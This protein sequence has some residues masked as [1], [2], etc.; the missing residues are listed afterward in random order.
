MKLWSLPVD[1]PVGTLMLLLSL[2]VLGVVALFLLPLD[3]WPTIEPPVISVDVPYPGSHPLE[4]LR[5]VARPLE[6]EISTIP[7]IKHLRAWANPDG[8]G[9]RVEFDWAV[10]LDIKKMDVREAVERVRDELPTGIGNI[11]IQSFLDAPGD[12]TIL[13]GRISAER[14]LSD[15][16][17]LLDRRIR[18]PLERIQGVARVDLGGVEAQ[19]VR[20]DVDPEALRRHGVHAGELSAA[21]R[22]ANLDMALGAIHGDVVR[23]DVRAEGRFRDLDEIRNLTLEPGGIRV[24]DVATVTLEEPILDYGRHLD[25]EF[26][27]SIE[28][29]PESSANTVETVDMLMARIEEFKADPELE[30]IQLLVWNNAGEQIRLA[31]RGLR[32]A[33]MFGGG[34]AVL[35]LFF[36][37]RRVRTTLIVAVAI[38]FSLLVTCGAMFF[39]DAHMNVLTMLGLMLGVGMLVDNGV[40]VIEN[41]YRRQGEGMEAKKAARIGTQEVALAVVASTATTVIVWSWLW[42]TEPSDFTIILGQIALTICLSVVCSL[43]ISL[44]FIPLAAAH[45]VPSREVRPGFLLRRIVPSYRTILGWTLRHRFVTLLGL[46]FLAGSAAIPIMRI[47]KSSST[48][49]QPRE[50]PVF[51]NSHGPASKEVMEAYVNRVEAWIYDN[52]EALEFES[53]YSWY[54]GGHAQTRIY[55]PMENRTEEGAERLREQLR[56]G[57]PVIPGV[58]MEVGDRERHRHRGKQWVEVALHGEDPEFLRELASEVEERL[59]GL[60]GAKEIYGPTLRGQH[61]A[62]IHVDPDKARALG[63]TPDQIASTVAFAYR[64]QR[65]RRFHGGRGEV[66]MLLGLPED[67]QPGVGSLPDLA[68]PRA[69]GDT[70][71]LG[72]V[73]EIVV[74]R[75][76]QRINREDRQTT[77]FV[78]ADM[79][80][81]VNTEDTRERIRER[82]AGFTLPQGYT[83]DWGRSGHDRDEALGIMLRGVL[84]SLLVVVLLMAALFESITQPLAILVTL[85]LAL[86]GGFWALW[87]FNFEF[88]IVAFVGLTILIGIVVNNG[89]VMVDHVNNLRR[90]GMERVPALIQGCGDRLRP[91]L[92]TAITTIFGLTPLAM[93]AFMVVDVYIDSL[94]VMVI[95][96]LATS[97]IF[98]LLAL[99]VWYTTLEDLG[100]VVSRAFPRWERKGLPAQTRRGVLAGDR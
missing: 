20:I 32:N 38:P 73:A 81:G 53:V 95:G 29:Y 17:D 36:F 10:D 59:R 8:A 2:T 11:R 14:D 31:L 76:D 60:E 51:Y 1:R 43:V 49:E 93:S 68:I 24:R 87:I 7:D 72:S 90:D 99:P 83:W 21:L 37:L 34:L 50:I 16:W 22:S 27:I 79:E 35:V 40:V 66:E 45:F 82:M 48:R 55:L 12:G 28:V 5:T 88:E 44:T 19:Q 25:R 15:S 78:G 97:T 86:F 100:S 54:Q 77:A 47:E 33:G 41:I 71:P 39:L 98:T 84:I 4:V 13:E 94:A 26:A 65:L 75:T 46:L 69:E 80:K 18:R 23:Y 56:E 67:L 63:L 74:A 70:V 30:G 42:V 85:P 6:E 91:V 52:R 61:E 58:K 9:V 57:L 3:Y 89:I 62:R 96:G 64:G 92:M